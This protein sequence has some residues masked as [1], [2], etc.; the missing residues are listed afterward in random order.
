MPAGCQP[1]G[2]VVAC[3]GAGVWSRLSKLMQIRGRMMCG[4]VAL[5]ILGECEGNTSVSAAGG[6]VRAAHTA[7]C[8]SG[9]AAA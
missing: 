4:C 9:H 8:D 7:R 3:S 5:C 1:E 6:A 2:I